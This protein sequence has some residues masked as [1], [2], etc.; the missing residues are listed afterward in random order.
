V[1]SVVPGPTNLKELAHHRRRE[2]THGPA[3]PTV[4]VQP[5]PHAQP[6]AGAR[7]RC[8]QSGREVAKCPDC[9]P[10]VNLE[11]GACTF[12]HDHQNAGRAHCHNLFIDL[13]R[14]YCP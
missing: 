3:R 8:I 9:H 2:G 10:G 4:V 12:A 1:D 6:F 14:Q 13:G 5:I 11:F 7:R